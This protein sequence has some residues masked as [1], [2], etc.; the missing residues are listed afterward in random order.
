MSNPRKIPSI[1]LIVDGKFAD[2]FIEV[3]AAIGCTG[4]GRM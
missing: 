4:D 3:W 1:K 2:S